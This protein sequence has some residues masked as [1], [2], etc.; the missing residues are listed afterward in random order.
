MA[1]FPRTSLPPAAKQESKKPRRPKTS[2]HT[3]ETPTRNRSST[4]KFHKDSLRFTRLQRGTF[5]KSRSIDLANSPVRTPPARPP[6]RRT[7]GTPRQHA[8][9][10]RTHSSQTDLSPA[11]CAR[12]GTRWLNGGEV[13]RIPA[14]HTGNEHETP[15]VDRG[16]CHE[17]SLRHSSGHFSRPS[18]QSSRGNRRGCGH[19]R[20]SSPHDHPP[21][22][23]TRAARTNRAA[24]TENAT[25]YLGTRTLPRARR[26]RTA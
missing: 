10:P 19:T 3:Q 5:A 24:P 16:N 15:R 9:L 25:G 13:H 17:T 21:D 11:A 20:S 8:R 23:R 18:D 7:A 22:H 12:R 1:A 26:R 2:P 6:T 14:A 4:D